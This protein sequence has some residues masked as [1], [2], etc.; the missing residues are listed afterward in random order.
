VIANAVLATLQQGERIDSRRR[1]GFR[2]VGLRITIQHGSFVSHGNNTPTVANLYLEISFVNEKKLFCTLM[3][4][5]EFARIQMVAS[6]CK[7]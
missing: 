4:V 5:A 7:N 3:K 2:S 1:G 6:N